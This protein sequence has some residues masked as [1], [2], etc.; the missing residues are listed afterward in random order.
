MK[1]K[2]AQKT[3]HIVRVDISKRDLEF[4]E[5]ELRK[6]R[7][8]VPKIDWSVQSVIEMYFRLYLELEMK[9]ARDG[10]TLPDQYLKNDGTF[11][12]K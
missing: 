12:P 6:W 11:V 4:L 8:L 5:G 7:V 3:T 10:G 9:A 1:K 2:T